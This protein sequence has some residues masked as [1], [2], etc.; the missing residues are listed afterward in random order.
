MA[1][2]ALL[3]FLSILTHIRLPPTPLWCRVF[4]GPWVAIYALN[5]NTFLPSWDW[6]TADS[7]FQPQLRQPLL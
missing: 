4:S 1:Y 3:S 6:D 7:S 5:Q 2:E